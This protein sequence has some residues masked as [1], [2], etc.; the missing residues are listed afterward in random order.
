[1]VYVF[2]IVATFAIV[3]HLVAYLS[4]LRIRR[5]PLRSAR[6][7]PSVSILKPL[8]GLDDQLETNLESFFRLDAP[9]TELIFCAADPDEPALEVV[10]QLQARYPE[11]PSRIVVGE[12]AVGLN[13][14]VRVLARGTRFARGEVLVVSDSNVRVR[15]SFLRETLAELEAPEVAVVSNLVAG[16]GERT[17][18]ASLENL[19]LNGFITPAICLGLTLRLPP[20]VVGKSMTI[21]RADLEAI[22]GW[23]SLGG[24]LAEDYVLGRRLSERG[25]RAIISSHV[26]ETVNEHWSLGR[27]IERHDRWLKMRWRI[28][29]VAL[30]F[31]VGVNV[32]LWAL[33][34]VLVTGGAAPVLATAG[35]YI[36]GRSVLDATATAALRPGR[37]LSPSQLIVVPARDL[38]LA[39]LWLHARFSRTIRWR[40]GQ[41]LLIGRNSLLSTADSTAPTAPA[42]GLPDSSTEPL[43]SPIA[44]R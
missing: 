29:P 13:P 12:E 44:R 2:F 39:A 38:A 23:S 19:Q 42:L 26:V 27:F 7:L 25:R 9:N 33:A 21:R 35:L 20:C 6:T 4:V 41:R 14:K 1:M 31:E 17:L 22:G 30:F 5:R 3:T 11:V 28:N 16:V 15:P 40:G 32:T 34:A 43:L 8:K 10:R 24:V 37:A 18:G 36:L